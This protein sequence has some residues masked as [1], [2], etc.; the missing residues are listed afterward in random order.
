MNAAELALANSAGS[1]GVLKLRHMSG[2]WY[3]LC[4][5]R[6]SQD[7]YTESLNGIGLTF[8]MKEVQLPVKRGG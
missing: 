5:F 6:C 4:P 8:T 7:M 1:Q 3:S 2:P